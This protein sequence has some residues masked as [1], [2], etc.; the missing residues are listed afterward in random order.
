MEGLARD[1]FEDV[2]EDMIDNSTD[3]DA[4]D[5]IESQSFPD[6]DDTCIEV[7]ANWTT[8]HCDCTGGHVGRPLVVNS[9]NRCHNSR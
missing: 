6:F 1:V 3:Q 2:E 4:N 5:I 8:M 9:Y 7:F